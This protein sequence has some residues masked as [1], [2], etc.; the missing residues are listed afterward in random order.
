MTICNWR[1]NTATVATRTNSGVCI[2]EQIGLKSSV[3]NVIYFVLYYM[4]ILGWL[5]NKCPT[6]Q[7]AISLQPEE[8]FRFY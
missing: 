6:R 5:R 3:Y 7:E 8:F 4:F 2:A 1:C